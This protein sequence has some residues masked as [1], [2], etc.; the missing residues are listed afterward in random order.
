MDGDTHDFLEGVQHCSSDLEDPRIAA[1][2]KHLLLDIVVAIGFE[3]YY[4]PGEC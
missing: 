3:L 4:L 2:C 1:S